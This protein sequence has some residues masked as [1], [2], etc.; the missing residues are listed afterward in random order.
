MGLCYDP[1]LM[2]EP[3]NR[4]TI[5][6]RFHA[7][8]EL[9]DG[10]DPAPVTERDLDADAEEFIVGWA[11][12]LGYA[13][14]FNVVIHLADD[15]RAHAP[16]AIARPAIHRYFAHKA[17]VTRL[18]LKRLLREARLALFIGILFLVSCEGLREI[19][20]AFAAPPPQQGALLRMLEE[21]LLIIGWVAMWK[22]LELLLYDWW[23]I[24]AKRRVY[25]KLAKA[26]VE[27]RFGP[28]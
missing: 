26:D 12:E 19:I 15:Q 5:A 21:G 17:E 11:R 7:L 4:E 10:M 6:V 3:S 18:D 16:E 13:K 22:P 8:D 25:E 23:P 1:R 9:F 14:D 24:R 2:V 20:R 27:V 28:E